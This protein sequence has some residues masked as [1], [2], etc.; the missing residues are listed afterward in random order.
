M[1]ELGLLLPIVGIKL[2]RLVAEPTRLQN[3]T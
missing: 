2:S 1:G 3:R